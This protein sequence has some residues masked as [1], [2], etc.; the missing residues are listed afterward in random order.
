MPRSAQTS[1][2]RAR[3]KRR[4]QR[5]AELEAVVE[6]QATEMD[7]LVKQLQRAKPRRPRMSATRSIWIAGR[8]GFKCAGDKDTCPCWLLRDGVFGPEGWQVDHIQRWADGYD[9]RDANCRGLCATCHFRVTKQQLMREGR[10]E[11]EDE[12]EEDD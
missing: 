9:N 11:D 3:L 2:P 12:D 1:P 4:Q 10:D 6:R 5:I 8:Q 7:H